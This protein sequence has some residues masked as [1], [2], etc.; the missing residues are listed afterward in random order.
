MKHP[1]V[2]CCTATYRAYTAQNDKKYLQSLVVMRTRLELLRVASQRRE[3]CPVT[4][5]PMLA[6]VKY[7]KTQEN[8]EI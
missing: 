1:V 3:I 8:S 6:G 2:R 7:P 4:K 5:Q